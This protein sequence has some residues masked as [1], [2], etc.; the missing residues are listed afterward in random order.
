MKQDPVL[1]SP[2]IQE[3]IHDLK[4]RVYYP[5][6]DAL[7]GLSFLAV[8]FY[9]AYH[10]NFGTSVLSQLAGFLYHCLDYSIDV[11]FV[12]SSFLLTLLGINEYREKGNFSF[13]NYFTRRA[14]RIWPLYYVIMF[15]SFVVLAVATNYL[16][17]HVSLP[18]AL[19]YL[20]FVSNFYTKDHVYFLRFLWTLSAEEQ[21]YLLLGISLA[22]F[23]K[24][25]K[26]VFLLLITGGVLFCIW[27]AL[28]GMN[29]YFNT[30]SYIFDFG[31]GAMAA[32]LLKNEYGFLN[33]LREMKKPAQVIFYGS[34]LLFLVSVFFMQMNMNET[35]GDVLSVFMRFTFIIFICA[36]IIVQMNPENAVIKIG[37]SRFLV[38]TGKLSYGLYCF[39]GI[40]LT[41]GNL[42][43]ARAEINMHPLLKALL[44]LAVDFGIAAVSYRFLEKRFLRLKDRFRAVD[45][46][47]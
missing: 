30:L 8:F 37:N 24:H 42:L 36:V 12:L 7:R 46:E 4:G 45:S 9:H 22:F 23:Q 20:F 28:S 38:Y 35:A 44:F 5:Q 10:L 29:V 47:Q 2:K 32:L 31:A 18:P 41:A 34:I 26:Y 14:L 43:L 27:A 19:P 11:F 17:V 39:H 25:L 13:K 3:N 6:L 40:V 1:A 33:R 16:N 15:F 21:F